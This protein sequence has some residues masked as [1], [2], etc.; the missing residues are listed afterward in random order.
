MVYVIPLEA[1]HMSL[2][3]CKDVRCCVLSRP[4]SHDYRGSLRPYIARLFAPQERVMT[5]KEIT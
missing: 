5:T 1:M 4:D 3:R 2:E